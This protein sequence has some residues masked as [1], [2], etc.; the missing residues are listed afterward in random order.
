MRLV[1]L[2]YWQGFWGV[3]CIF[4]VVP[5]ALVGSISGRVWILS[6]SALGAVSLLGVWVVVGVVGPTNG[7]VGLVTLW[8]SSALIG[9]HVEDGVICSFW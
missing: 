6:V 9:S 3:D 2:V 5:V 7:S 8:W 1:Y 4:V